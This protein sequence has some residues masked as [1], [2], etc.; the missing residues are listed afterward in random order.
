MIPKLLSSH[1]GLL[2]SCCRHRFLPQQRWSRTLLP[3]YT[4]ARPSR[5]SVPFSSASETEKSSST[6]A[7]RLVGFLNGAITNYPRETLVCLISTEVFSVFACHQALILAGVTVPAEFALA[8]ALSK[9][10][11]LL[12]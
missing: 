10:P 12:E 1:G 8:F 7:D 11:S 6:R 5:G 3:G 4:L 9:F 2:R